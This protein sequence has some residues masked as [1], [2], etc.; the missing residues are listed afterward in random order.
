MM[1]ASVNTL[2]SSAVYIGYLILR[3]IKEQNTDKI[4]IYDISKALKQEGISSSRQ[5]ITGLSFLF[6]VDLIDFE[7]ANIWVKK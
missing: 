1:V 7:E 2:K 3:E 6:S 4:S 5:L